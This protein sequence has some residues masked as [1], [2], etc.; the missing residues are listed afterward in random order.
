M[1]IV[2]ATA[3]L[4]FLACLSGPSY[5]QSLSKIGKKLDPTNRNSAPRSIGR[6]IDRGRPLGTNSRI[7]QA[8]SLDTW[9]G[10]EQAQAQANADA[11]NRAR[12]EYQQR[13]W[14]Q[15]QLA[16]QHHYR[17][18]QQAFQQQ[19]IQQE[20]SRQMLEARQYQKFHERQQIFDAIGGLIHGITNGFQPSGYGQPQG[21][22]YPQQW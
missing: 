16:Q 19:Q 2:S 8:N 18:Q 13:Q 17:L 12:A 10:E 11:Q 4:L 15:Q 22:Y 9:K 3:C 6:A 7:P 20:R 14:E 21:Y 1:K 5:G